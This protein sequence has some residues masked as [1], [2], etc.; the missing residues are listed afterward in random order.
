MHF[1][2]VRDIH[3]HSQHHFCSQ[4]SKATMLQNSTY[5]M[6]P[7]AGEVR[8]IWRDSATVRSAEQGHSGWHHMANE[9]TDSKQPL[10]LRAPLP[11]YVRHSGQ[12]HHSSPLS[13]CNSHVY[14]CLHIR[15]P[16]SEMVRRL[17]HSPM[18]RRTASTSERDRLPIANS[19]RK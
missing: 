8:A 14:Q 19:R 17:L 12:V 10:L 4:S 2:R 15:I 16:Y 11:Q 13:T 18:H 3:W 7:L 1:T 6:E 5:Q 9:V